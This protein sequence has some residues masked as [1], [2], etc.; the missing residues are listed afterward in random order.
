MFLTYRSNS[1][2]SVSLSGAAAFAKAG[3]KTGLVTAVE[4]PLPESFNTR[5]DKADTI[6]V[7]TIEKA[8]GLALEAAFRFDE[9]GME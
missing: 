5:E 7:R 2:I 4:T 9:A 6:D 8:V 1:S 3:V